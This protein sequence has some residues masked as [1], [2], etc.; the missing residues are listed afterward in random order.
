M[1]LDT[2]TAPASE[3]S[4]TGTIFYILLGPVLWAA[5]LT[6]IYFLHSM[7]CAHVVAVHAIPALVVVATGVAV[8]VIALPMLAP[9]AASS[10]F[11]ASGWSEEALSFYARL[12][13]G[14]ALL[15]LA[16]V[17]WGGATALVIPECAALR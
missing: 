10:V 4:A 12:M 17:V 8:V 7:L 13:R 1:D 11:R 3:R 6:L 9:K 15:S 5:H 14:L 16:G 2:A